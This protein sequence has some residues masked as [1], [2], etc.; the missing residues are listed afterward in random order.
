MKP[1]SLVSFDTRTA[2]H[3]RATL[4]SSSARLLF[5]R[6]RRSLCFGPVAALISSLL[7]KASR[8]RSVEVSVKTS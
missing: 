4:A 5:C 2:A 7:Y 1:G 8:E 3:S 6:N